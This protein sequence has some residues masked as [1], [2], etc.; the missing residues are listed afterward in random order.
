MIDVWRQSANHETS[1]KLKKTQAF[2]SLCFIC[3]ET[4]TGSADD[5]ERLHLN[6][7]FDRINDMRQYRAPSDIMAET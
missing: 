5:A 2:E 1:K 3:V 7:G 4:L 6:A